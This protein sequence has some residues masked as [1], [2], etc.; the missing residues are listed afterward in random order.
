MAKKSTKKEESLEKVLWDAANKLRKNI[1]A[2]EYKHVVLGLIFLRYVS[3][4]FEALYTKLQEGKGEYA[5][6]DPEDKDEYKAEN[7]FFVPPSAR[8]KF[9]QSHAKQ[10][11]IGKTVDEAMDALER[12]NAPLK[13]VLPKV[14]AKENLD[15]TS[16]GQLID[17]ISN[18][19]WAM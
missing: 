2:A 11:T 4:S 13:G 10:A 17:K 16:L 19:Q 9:L 8:W 1:D 18:M 12:E 6:A 7:V 3:D 15:A 5:G 14:Y